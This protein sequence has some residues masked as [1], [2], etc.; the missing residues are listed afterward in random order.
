MLKYLNAKKFKSF[1]FPRL[2]VAALGFIVNPLPL[3]AAEIAEK[4]VHAATS[5]TPEVGQF[6]QP[7]TLLTLPDEVLLKF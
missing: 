2:I 3:E 5:N 4:P 1:T 6:P 7:Q